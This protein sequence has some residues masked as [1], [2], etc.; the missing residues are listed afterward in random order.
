MRPLQGTPAHGPGPAGSISRAPKRLLLAQTVPIQSRLAERQGV[1][2]PCHCHGPGASRSS[3]RA[4]PS[5]RPTT[6]PPR[7]GS[8]CSSAAARRSMPPSPPTPCSP[9]SIRTWPASAATCSRSSGT[10]ARRAARSAS[11]PAAGP[12]PPPPSTGT[13]SRGH[14]AIPSRGP[15]ACVTVPGAVDGWWQLHQRTR[16]AALGQP[17]RAGHRACDRRLRRAGEPRRLVHPERRRPGRRSDRARHVPPERPAAPDG[18][19]PRDCRPSARTLRTI[20]QDGPDAFYRGEI[21]EQVCAYL[22]ARGG[23]LTPDDFA[24]NATTL[25]QPITALVSRLHRLPAAAEHPGL[26]RPGDA[27]HPRRPRRRRARATRR[28]PTSTPSPRRRGW[29]SR[30]ATAT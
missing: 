19:A 2:E 1:T 4:A 29:R 26:R 23:L 21:A 7:P 20:A 13:Q 6:P 11:T 25:G 16:S 28:R 5:P 17:V 18:R 9:S 3:P 12:A 27:R 30:T 10:P 14:D 24:A 22:Q 8:A 15:L